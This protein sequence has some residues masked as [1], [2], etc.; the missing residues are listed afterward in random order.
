MWP[1]VQG[2]LLF[3]HFWSCF[4]QPWGYSLGEIPTG[5]P[6]LKNCFD[7]RRLQ[8]DQRI[9]RFASAIPGS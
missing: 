7:Q 3:Q 1:L 8:P 6:V 9:A 2:A 5:K 4:V